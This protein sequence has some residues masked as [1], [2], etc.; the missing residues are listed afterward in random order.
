MMDTA[1]GGMRGGFMGG[2]ILSFLL[3]PAALFS[4][5]AVLY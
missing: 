3:Y 5:S 2:L 4:F 1:M